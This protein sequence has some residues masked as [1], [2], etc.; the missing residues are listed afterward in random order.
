MLTLM[1]I[2][3]YR[4]MPTMSRINGARMEM[5]RNMFL[6]GAIEKGVEVHDKALKAE[7]KSALQLQGNPSIVLR[8][9]TVGYE[10]LETPVL[11]NLTH[12]FR[13]GRIHGIVGASGSGKKHARKCHAGHPPLARRRDFDYRWG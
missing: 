1:A 11:T 2:G 10:A 4:I 9:L 8:N 7:G 6:L 13:P 3:A 5:K 12:A